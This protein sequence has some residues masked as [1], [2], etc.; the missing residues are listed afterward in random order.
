[1]GCAGSS[2]SSSGSDAF[3]ACYT[4]GEKIGQGS[5]GQVRWCDAK[6]AAGERLAVKILTLR[7]ASPSSGMGNIRCIS[8]MLDPVT[9]ELMRNAKTETVLWRQIGYHDHCVQLHEAFSDDHLCY[10]VMEACQCS[11]FS[12]LKDKSPHASECDLLRVIHEVLQALHHIHG[13][14]IVHR[15]VKPDNMLLGGPD[16][17]VS[18]LCDFGLAA[19]L[20]ASGKM[21]G[22]VGTVP[23]MSP[24]MLNGF[25]YTVK[26][27]V[28]SLGVT[29]YVMLYGRFPYEPEIR[30]ADNMKLAIASGLNHPEYKPIGSH[31]RPSEDAS[32]IV[33]GLLVWR[34]G[35]RDNTDD[36]LASRTGELLRRLG[37]STSVCSLTSNDGDQDTSAKPEG[38]SKSA[39]FLPV[40][41][42]AQQEV[43][44]FTPRPDPL[45][46]NDIDQLLIQIGN[47]EEAG[48]GR[49]L[50][51][52]AEVAANMR[53]NSSIMRLAAAITRK[54]VTTG[55]HG[56]FV[57]GGV[58]PCPLVPLEP[59]RENDADLVC[60]AKDAS[61][62][63][64][65]APERRPSP[66]STPTLL[67]Q[68]FAPG[69]SKKKANTAD[70][71]FVQAAPSLQDLI[72][73]SDC[74]KADAVQMGSVPAGKEAELQHPN[75]CLDED[76]DSCSLDGPHDHHATGELRGRESCDPSRRSSLSTSR[77][78]SPRPA[79]RRQSPGAEDALQVPRRDSRTTS[80]TSGNVSKRES[81]SGKLQVPRRES[82]STSHTS[83][84]SCD[85]R[86]QLRKLFSK[87]G[88][89]EAGSRSPSPTP[90]TVS[91]KLPYCLE[92]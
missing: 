12:A 56:S 58:D 30:T 50:S 31:P 70:G 9:R 90:D 8:T 27:D 55:A 61:R 84:A 87:L 72:K 44:D 28:W 57:P 85:S 52:P 48:P 78:P 65:D 74:T 88:S 69:R 91:P 59:L 51:M 7:S 20:P 34:H 83:N 4:L 46:Q 21:R 43:N 5:F 37:R 24:E 1:M 45:V 82:R 22:V 10:L 41:L 53:R 19:A 16:G 26:T 33:R 54:R 18:K 11:V 13:R 62:A 73:Q 66:F 77:S 29:A 79:Q 36:V 64:A 68:R 39:S 75:A 49:S 42:A 2:P 76:T 71:A 40:L 38:V 81:L 14:G 32:R 47:E 15:D 89:R 3:H 23:Y 6:G 60:S 86:Q 63:P 92:A 67:Q 17:T 80:D 35:K 25:A